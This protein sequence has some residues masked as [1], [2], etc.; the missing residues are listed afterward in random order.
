M[1]IAFLP[2]VPLLCSNVSSCFEI[3]T[4]RKLCI[5]H[6]A[7]HT[8]VLTA[9]YD[10]PFTMKQ[11]TSTTSR[12]EQKSSKQLCLSNREQLSSPT[13]H[14]SSSNKP[15]R[16]M[17]GQQTSSSEQN[18]TN[19]KKSSI[20]RV[21]NSCSTTAERQLTMTTQNI[22]ESVVTAKQVSSKNK[23]SA[24]TTEPQPP[25]GKHCSTGKKQ[26]FASMTELN[27]K[28][29]SST[30]KQSLASTKQ[31]LSTVKQSLSII[32]PQ[33][34]CT[35]KHRTNEQLQTGAKKPPVDEELKEIS[36]KVHRIAQ[37]IGVLF[38]DVLESDEGN[39]NNPEDRSYSKQAKA[40]RSDPDSKNET[41]HK[42][43]KQSELN[44]TRKQQ[45][46]INRGRNRN[47]T[48]NVNETLHGNETELLE[49]LKNINSLE[50]VRKTKTVPP[51]APAIKTFP[52][53]YLDKNNVTN[54]FD[55]HTA[56]NQVN[57][58]KT[59]RNN[60]K[61][62]PSNGKL[63]QTISEIKTDKTLNK[64]RTSLSSVET[65]SSNKFLIQNKTNTNNQGTSNTTISASLDNTKVNTSMKKSPIQNTQ[66]VWDIKQTEA[67]VRYTQTDRQKSNETPRQTQTSTR[68]QT[69]I[70]PRTTF[71]PVHTD[72]ACLSWGNIGP[73]LKHLL[74]P[75]TSEAP[76]KSSKTPTATPPYL[77]TS[78]PTVIA[79]SE[80]SSPLVDIP[81]SEEYSCTGEFLQREECF[82][83]HC[84][85]E[86][87]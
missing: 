77:L 76:R 71:N 51:T 21:E 50:K 70:H 20:M 36:N 46:I 22:V 27:T 54:N 41:M 33:L 40:L 64:T 30:N 32:K 74:Q 65:G 58:E 38:N 55:A 57:V 23:Q 6:K 52:I 12:E 29:L 25:N 11:A 87:G 26:S 19:N 80:V 56:P 1:F 43:L 10:N 42:I 15:S 13:K 69:N 4:S 79:S 86:F 8:D 47:G 2:F 24:P 68:T 85:G 44:T 66:F 84:P 82:V 83:Q 53:L 81:W 63:N 49:K 59:T 62:E 34:S 31:C 61:H 78:S 17:T 73:Q 18:L 28:Q 72:K 5:S 16:V 14:C 37:E 3:A 75:D 35:K 9:N 7:N 39:C 60:T 48:S 67:T 45:K